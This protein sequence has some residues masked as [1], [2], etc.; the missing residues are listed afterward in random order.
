MKNIAEREMCRPMETHELR[1]IGETRLNGLFGT[2]LR[3]LFGWLH[4]VR[5]ATTTAPVHSLMRL[6][7]GPP[8]YVC[9]TSR[10]DVGSSFCLVLVS[11]F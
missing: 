11:W 10:E 7:T 2:E 8:H 5:P 3:L 1:Q 6:S 9:K 4:S